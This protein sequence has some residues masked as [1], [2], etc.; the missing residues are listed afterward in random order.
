MLAKVDAEGIPEYLRAP[1]PKGE[2]PME[3]EVENPDAAGKPD[4]VIPQNPLL[5]LLGQDLLSDLN[6][7]PG[8]LDTFIEKSQALNQ[9]LLDLKNNPPP[10]T[11]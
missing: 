1:K 3:P 11:G 2:V 10:N 9:R 5:A 8:Q 6:I 4:P 7:L